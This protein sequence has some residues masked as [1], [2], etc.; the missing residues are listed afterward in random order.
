MKTSDLI[1]PVIVI[2]KDGY[3][4]VS[5]DED[6]LTTLNAASI[7]RG[8]SKDGIVVDS[9]GVAAHVEDIRFVSGKGAFWGYT[10]WLD[11]ICRVEM[12]L[13]DPYDI[14]FEQVKSIVEKDLRRGLSSVDGQ[15]RRQLLEEI[16]NAQSIGTLIDL[17]LPHADLRDFLR[18][19]R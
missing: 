12:Q 13:S 2:D 19:L 5:V 1:Y 16:N 4:W 15:F 9:R 6:T 11:R 17:L 8:A 18:S 3:A 7:K 14:S 10:I